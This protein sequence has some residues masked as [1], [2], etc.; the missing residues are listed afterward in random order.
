MQLC[1]DILYCLFIL[2]KNVG[3]REKCKEE[4]LYSMRKQQ[5]RTME[6]LTN[7]RRVSPMFIRNAYIVIILLT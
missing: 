3:E 4:V 7:L 5:K 1:T 2:P 6:E